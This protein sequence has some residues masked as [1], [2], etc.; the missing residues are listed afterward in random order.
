VGT[1]YFAI[2]PDQH[3]QGIE[4]FCE[5]CGYTN[6]PQRVTHVG[7]A[8]HGWRF[9][10]S[11][12]FRTTVAGWLD[13]LASPAVRIFSEYGDRLDPAEFLNKIV[14]PRREERS[15]ETVDALAKP[16][17]TDGAGVLADIARGH[18]R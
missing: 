13:Y 4:V 1:N 17:S 7:K 9:L 15:H 12:D 5:H 10:F 8:S 14:I 6:R 18:F 16:K 2:E 3:A 11:A